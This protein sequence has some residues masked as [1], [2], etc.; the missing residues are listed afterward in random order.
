VTVALTLLGDVRW[1]GTPVAGE[2]SQAL[3]AALAAA[4]GRPVR[5]ERLID[6]VWADE[7][8]ANST[9]SL[10]VL[11]SRTRTALG[12]GVIVREPV[13][14]RLGVDP[15][16]VDC[17]RLAALVRDAAAALDDDAERAATLAR[18]AVALADGLRA[19]G[20]DEADPLTEVRRAAAG[21][22]ATASAI[23]AQSLSRT[24][25]H[26]QA[27]PRLE[28]AHAARADDEA[29]LTDLLRSEAVV[30]GPGAALERY[31]VYRQDLLERLGTNPG[32]RLSRAH[33]DLL[34]LDRPVRSGVRHDASSLRGRDRDIARL[35][36]LLTHARV[37]S[38]VGPGGL[39]KTRLAHVLARDA[40]QSV[41]HVVEL[42]GV[43]AAED[44]VGEVGSVL[45]VRD[46][47]SAQRTLTPEQ[48]LDLRGRVAQRLAQGP[49]LVVLDNCEHVIGAVA[50]L[51]AYL[52]SA[53]ADLRVLTTSRAPLEIAAE[54]VYLLGE[55]EPPDAVALFCDRALAA[56]P[57]AELPEHLVQS[58]V[59]RLDGLPLAIELAAAKVRAMAVEEIDRR[60]ED[61]FALLRG[62][63]RG[64]PDRHQTLLAVIDWSWNLIDEAARRALRRL[65]LFND[66]FTLEAAEAVLGDGALDA[67]QGLVDQSLLSVREAAGGVRYRMLETVREFGRLQLARAGEDGEARAARRAWATAYAERHRAGLSDRDQFATI[68]AIAVEEV[69]LAD[70]LR[71]ALADGDR[72]ALVE[73]LSVLGL[74]WTIRGEHGRLVALTAAVA[75]AVRDWHPPP[76]LEDTARAALVMTMMGAMVTADRR[77]EPIR[78]LL[79]RL[80]PG[81]GDP[82]LTGM[83]TMLLAYDPADPAAFPARL[84]RLASDPDPHVA[85]PSLQFV[86][87]ARENV[88]DPASAVEAAAAALALV[89]DDEGPWAPAQLHT[90]LADLTMNLGDTVAAAAHARAALPVMERLGATDDVLQLRSLL[91]LCAIAEGRLADA[92]AELQR[93]DSIDDRGALFGGIAF[94][95]IG[96]AELAL[97]RG[98]VAAGL[99]LYRECAAALAGL[100][101][102]GIETTGM[103]PWGVLGES[104]ALGAHAHHAASDAD[105]AYAR[106]LFASSRERVLRVLDPANAQLDYPVAGLALFAL[107][108]W[109]LLRDAAPVEDAVEL[110][111]LAE[112]FAY[113]RMIPTM[114]WERIAP[115]TE[116]RAPGRIAALRDEL[117]DRRPP[118][119]LDRAHGLVERLPD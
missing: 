4:G 113:N 19:P 22:L 116:A 18:D 81:G 73:L 114:A 48:R 115:H 112:R 51:V 86:A 28:A 12:A 63:D 27:L 117:G 10:Q 89:R 20:D 119:L 54:H 104:I 58:I 84:E 111:V 36:A 71:D 62:G 5:A 72:R 85:R 26:A 95:Q 97:A 101:L 92:E 108:A 11:V 30:R 59:T 49:S 91:V 78:E 50:E 13:G 56:R 45:D 98:D 43:T 7:L 90:N 80:G 77:S 44:V 2:R 34:A 83:V 9:K 47:V 118:E 102:P 82:R 70:E 53:T 79:A 29:V 87:R 109:G 37:V 38:I 55:L 75:D 99:R 3:L 16:E 67:V 88:G 42:V 93:V 14:Y 21:D 105:A 68:D 106:G 76:E 103:E 60:L 41:V 24:G 74:F 1:R 52:V 15:A 39:G 33:R 57:G 23:L 8:P 61:R 69:N 17:V 31:E 32:E 6:L 96:G 64:A 66:G 40:T 65:A 100:R 46:S 25:A 110:L 107:A 35:R 94:G